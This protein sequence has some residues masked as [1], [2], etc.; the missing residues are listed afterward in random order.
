MMIFSSIIR[1]VI[2]R[3]FDCVVT[4]TLGRN[5]GYGKVKYS[6]IIFKNPNF[7][8]ILWKLKDH[9]ERELESMLGN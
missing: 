5:E 7:I 4:V 8:G 9:L 6:T 3:A 2:K 1:S